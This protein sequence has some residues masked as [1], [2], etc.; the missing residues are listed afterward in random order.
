MNGTSTPPRHRRV[1]TVVAAL[2]AVAGLVL[3]VTAVLGQRSAPEPVTSTVPAPPVVVNGPADLPV[4]AGKILPAATP[5]SVAIPSIGV[6][7]V[8]NQVG[9]N[10]DGTLQV[11]APGPL[12][13]EAAWYRDSAEPGTIGPAVILGHIDSKENGPSVFFDLGRVKSG[14]RI[15]VNR[16]DGT[17]ATFLVDSVSRFPKDEFP[18]RSVYGITDRA[19][20]RVITCSGSFDAATGNYRD[21]TV[22][23]AHLV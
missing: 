14:D 3:L 5:T 7:S 6:R 4:P 12:Y 18:S 15:D 17:V 10:P 11:P 16:S 23:F 19:E 1:A 13:D 22:V 20:L 9:L 21:N 2:L 8:L